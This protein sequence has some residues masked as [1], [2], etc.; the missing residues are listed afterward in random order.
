MA[1]LYGSEDAKSLGTIVVIIPRSGKGITSEA[2]GLG[3]HT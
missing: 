3:R 2:V 1:I